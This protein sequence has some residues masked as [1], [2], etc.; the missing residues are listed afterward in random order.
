MEAWRAPADGL[1][2]TGQCRRFIVD[3]EELQRRDIDRL[4]RRW[5]DTASQL[6]KDGWILASV[7]FDDGKMVGVALYATAAS[8]LRAP[9][10]EA[11]PAFHVKC[12]S[13]TGEV[14]SSLRRAAA[15]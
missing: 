11:L 4:H 3:R 7:F 9:K 14:C 12:P 6:T 8:R 10:L 5:R 15:G 2:P 13:L 1:T